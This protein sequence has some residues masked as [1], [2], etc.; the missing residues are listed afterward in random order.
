MLDIW[1]IECVEHRR[2]E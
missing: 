2:I 1:W